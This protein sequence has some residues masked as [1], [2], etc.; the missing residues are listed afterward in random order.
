MRIEYLNENALKLAF[1]EFGLTKDDILSLPD[2]EELRQDMLDKLS[3][4]EADEIQ[5]VSDDGEEPDRLKA[6]SSLITAIT[7]EPAEEDIAD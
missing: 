2:N 5:A 1:E 6:V 4:I 7:Y 3:E